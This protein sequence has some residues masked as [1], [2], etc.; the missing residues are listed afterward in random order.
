MASLIPVILCGGSGSRLWPLSRELYPKQL[1]R[2]T[3]E[4]SLLQN[5]VKRLGDLVEDQ[6]PVFICNEDHRFM[7]AE[8]LRELGLKHYSIILEPV[9]K[10]TAPAIAL[11]ALHLLGNQRS[12]NM[13]V[14]PADH[15]IAEPKSL[16]NQAERANRLA[17]NGFLT[18][19]GIVPSQAETGYGYIQ[20]GDLLDEEEGSYQ[21]K[22][23]VEK[24]DAETAQKYVDSG[25][26]LWNSGMFVFDAQQ[27]L[28]TLEQFSPDIKSCCASA[29]SASSQDLDFIRI[30]AEAFSRCP[31]DSIDYAVMERADNV[32]VVPLEAGWNDI[33]SWSALWDVS[34]TDDNGNVLLGDTIAIDSRNNYVYSDSRLVATVGLDNHVVIETP[35]AVLV[36]DKNKVQDVKKV[37]QS[38]KA[39]QRSERTTHRRVFRPW[40]YYETV[41]AGDRYQV[42]R[43]GVN[44]DAS[45]S[46]Q[47]HFHRSE[48]WIVVKGTAEVTCGDKTFLVTENESTYIPV[49]E[50]H[51]LF[52][53]GK[54]T[55]E[56]IEV[57]SG[58]YLG[59][60]DIVRFED[61]YGRIASEP[62]KN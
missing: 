2:L 53:P 30:E 61:V 26:Y 24:P 6:A 44:P 57:Q 8:Q 20:Q 25:Q 1:L 10:N 43:I 4:F 13:L 37:V 49:G 9:G 27:Y 16:L 42:K 56:M 55:L 34:K 38:L 52:N 45:L 31:D 36:A 17:N 11:A 46:L 15:V 12:G 18:T 23:F 22:S 21:V 47:K 39:Q 29:I 58:S 51:R 14:L 3:D 5:T 19:F 50:K 54:Q 59:E 32:A 35:D 28:S 48:H 33:G 62:S 40:G 7:V 60:D 41:D